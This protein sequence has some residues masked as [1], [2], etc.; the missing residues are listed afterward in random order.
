MELYNYKKKLL[1][2]IVVFILILSII[3]LNIIRI[4]SFENHIFNNKTQENIYSIQNLDYCYNY[5]EIGQFDDNYGFAWS[6]SI[7][8]DY[9]YI[10][11]GI[12]GMYILD[13][14]SPT[15]PVLL[16]NFN[17]GGNAYEVFVVD[18]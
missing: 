4:N 8:D 2:L 6:A 5:S 11:N 17:D 14:S 16:S 9:L 12:G 3:S 10:A 7:F 18:K 15:T 1:P 13:I